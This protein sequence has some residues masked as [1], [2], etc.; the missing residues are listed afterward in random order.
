MLTFAGIDQPTAIQLVGSG[1]VVDAG[2]GNEQVIAIAPSSLNFGNVTVGQTMQQQFTV[3]NPSTTS[4]LVLNVTNPVFPF[5]I[6]GGAAGSA[7]IAPGESRTYTV[8]YTP[9]FAGTFGE[10]LL[11][12]YTSGANVGSSFI[13]LSGTASAVVAGIADEGSSSARAIA[14][15]PEPTAAGTTLRYA[16]S[17][18]GNVRLTVF[19]ARGREV[20]RLV[21]GAT[22]AGEHTITWNAEGQAA[23]VY[24]VQLVSS[25]GVAT[26]RVTLV[27]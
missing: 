25:D 18:S 20:A 22:E 8:S 21:D 1:V 9:T 23:G 17:A 11:I 3:T 26:G 24:V 13:G 14:S 10:N 5:F 15:F 16:T 2:G 6:Q 19:D 12:N 7:T 27:R 4:P